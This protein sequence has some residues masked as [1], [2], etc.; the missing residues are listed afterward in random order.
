MGKVGT[1]DSAVAA[2]A[3][4]AA[5]DETAGGGTAGA[6][7]V[8]TAAAPAVGAPPASKRTD[9]AGTNSGSTNTCTTGAEGAAMIS[10]ASS[11]GGA[12]SGVDKRGETP[13]ARC[14]GP[15]L[16]SAATAAG[17][18]LQIAVGG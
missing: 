14:A 17:S 8:S 9:P 3:V 6:G 5:A 15:T 11:C 10:V 7:A 1:G 16:R 4:G 13:S 18:E 2:A 12:T